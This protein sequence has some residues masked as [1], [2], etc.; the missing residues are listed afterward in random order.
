MITIIDYGMGNLR[1]IENALNF[2]GIANRI[3][4]SPKIVSESRQLLLPG[5]GSFKFA[6]NRL[7]S[8]GLD[9]S[10]LNSVLIKGANILGICLGMQMLAS[11]S[12]EDGGADGLALVDGVVSRFTSQENVGLKIPHIGFR[13]VIADS[14]MKLFY[15]IDPHSDFYFIHS[16]RLDS[17]NHFLSA[18]TQ[19]GENFV[20]AFENN[21]IFGVQF[22]PEKSQLNGLQLLKNFSLL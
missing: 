1:S 14:K 2:L 21:N 7:K 10:I 17:I 6:M 9:E 11:Y 4:D 18:E 20:S 19:Y 16:Y 13:E 8:R 15:K 3:T 22:H 12:E 5:V